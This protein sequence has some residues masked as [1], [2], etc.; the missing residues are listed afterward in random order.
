MELTAVLL[1]GDFPGTGALGAAGAQ[2]LDLPATSEAAQFFIDHVAQG[3]Q[4]QGAVLVLLPSWR[5]AAAKRLVSLA[6]GALSTDRIAAVQ[7]SL[8]PL[9][10]SLVADQ[11]AFVAPHVKPGVLA[12]L[13]YRLADSVYAGAWVNSVARLEHIKTGFGAHVSSFLPGGFSVG[14]G[15]NAGVHRITASKPVQVI[16]NRPQDPVLLLVTDEN[17]D[18]EWVQQKLQPELRVVSVTPVPVQPLSQEYWGAK[19]FSEF[20]ALCG[21]PRALHFAVVNATYRPCGWCRELTTLPKCP[22]CAMLQRENAG[23]SSTGPQVSQPG[24]PP[25]PDS[26]QAPPAPPAPHPQPP[27]PQP[28]GR[29][30]QPPGPSQIPADSQPP[31][32]GQ[33]QPLAQH[34]P[35]AHPPVNAQPPGPGR[36][37]EHVQPPAQTRPQPPAQLQPPVQLQ[38]PAQFQFAAQSSHSPP[39]QAD[40]R[41]P[42][43]PAQAGEGAG[44]GVP[45][46]GSAGP[47]VEVKGN[48]VLAAPHP[49]QHPAPAAPEPTG[50]AS[51]QTAGGTVPE[52]GDVPLVHTEVTRTDIGAPAPPPAAATTESEV[53]PAPADAGAAEEEEWPGRQG[54][55]RFGSASER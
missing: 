4:A 24:S 11:L 38:P 2:R 3:L 26:Q 49:A 53:R 14:A 22:F 29:P 48:G 27:P 50:P 34:Q 40:P 46:N 17:G 45:S 33:P 52:P 55:V 47:P 13:A 10:L 21:H 18:M 25:L 37:A 39:P 19:K 42:V 44:S 8:P 15:T 32:N 12:S 16:E 7:L 51:G 6:R 35:P 43:P 30:P 9:A 41:G 5:A 54:T 1:M 23:T 31:A 20:V 28:A 36:P